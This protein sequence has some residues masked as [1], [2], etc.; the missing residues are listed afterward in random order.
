MLRLSFFLPALFIICC[1]TSQAQIIN[2]DKA[3][4]SAYVKKSQWS[5]TFSIGLELDKQNQTLLDM[6][7]FADASLQHDHEL[8]I[9]SASNRITSNGDKSFLNTGYVHIRWRHNYKNRLHPE[10]FEQYQWDAQRGMIH[11]FLSGANLRYSL[12]HHDKWNMTFAT[13]V[14]YENEA[15]NYSAVDSSK[16]PANPVDQK[17]SLIKSNNYVK[18]DAQTSSNGAVSITLFYQATYTHF[19]QPRVSTFI[20][21]DIG[22]SK[23][24]SLSIKYSALYDVK[25][26]VPIPNFYYSLSTSLSYKL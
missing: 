8:F 24:F 23:H 9:L 18:W 13:G 10:T 16:I 12:P 11:R 1:L 26:V 14:M 5:A 15:W 2:I 4:T 20:S 7:N 21:Y 3:D 22:V 6:S 17:R 25:P 19:F